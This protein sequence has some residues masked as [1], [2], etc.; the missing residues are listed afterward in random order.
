M[1]T[2]LTN[3][4]KKELPERVTWTHTHQVAFDNPKI[5]LTSE[6]VLQ[7]PDYFIL[8]TNASD[9]GLGAIVT[10][11]DEKEGDHHIAFISRKLLPMEKNYIYAEVEKECLTIVEGVCD[12]S[13]VPIVMD[14]NCFRYSDKM[15]DVGGRLT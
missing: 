5:D 11:M 10:Q 12:G 6:P 1:A 4:T 2:P 14:H 15:N 7:G 3:L 13:A 8:Q 9:V